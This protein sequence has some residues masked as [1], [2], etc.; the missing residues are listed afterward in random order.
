[1][2]N[3]IIGVDIGTSGT[4]A[5]ALSPEGWV[6]SESYMAY[7]TI[8]PAP[9]RQELDPETLESAVCR[10]IMDSLAGTR[11][12]ERLLA[13]SFSSALHSLMAVDRSGVPLTRVMTW[14]DLRSRR[15]AGQIRNSAGSEAI[16]DH[17][18]TPIHPMSPLC[19]IAWL[20]ETH[21]EIFE[22][23]DK[24]LSIKEYIWYR[25]F[26][27]FQIDFSLASAT[28]LFDIHSR[29]WYPPA[30]RLAGITEDRLSKPVDTTYS[31][32]G[33]REEM[34]LRMGVTVD[35]LC[36]IGAGDGC[37]ANLGSGAMGPTDMALTIGTSAAVR[38]T[39]RKPF[40]DPERKLFHYILSGNWFVSGGAVNNGGNVIKWW[41][42]RFAPTADASG[43]GLS[44]S[45]DAIALVPPG[46]GG[47]V[48]LP[49]LFGERAPVWDADARAVFFGIHPDADPAWFL[50]SI[51][52]GITIGLH[53]TASYLEKRT[54]PVS[55]ILASGG[56]IRS[57]IWLQILADI[58]N[59]E[60]LVLRTGDASAIGAALL[61]WHALG[62]LPD[63]DRLP[64]ADDVQ[65]RFLPDAGSRAA[66]G[67]NY[68]VYTQ[69]YDQLRN[70]F[71]IIQAR[72][73]DRAD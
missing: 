73:P 63:L 56:F 9:D 67:R 6:I 36:V 41:L 70:D 58:F 64:G 28:G 26:G 31:A 60:V 25:F 3:F 13:I 23:T 72:T 2:T 12:P 15:Q 24:F 46:C 47:M 53:Q 27:K 8:S 16:Y 10:T 69:L 38:M 43:E 14:A 48:F 5:I 18:G 66:Y 20:R 1:V 19:K 11:E 71:Q 49:Y 51:V 40:H 45:L 65:E 44:A 68:G 37:L 39:V 30:L 61:G 54:G 42:D 34:R 35:T 33:L 57:R 55:R 21:P 4:K 17:T 29:N 32:R 59:K 62:R 52:E 22:R 7:P 50:R